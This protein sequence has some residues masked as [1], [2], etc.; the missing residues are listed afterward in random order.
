MT[1]CYP[2]PSG[3]SYSAE[4]CS[5]SRLLGFETVFLHSAHEKL[6]GYWDIVTDRL[7]KIRHC[8][9][10]PTLIAR[11]FAPCLKMIC[12][13]HPRLPRISRPLSHGTSNRS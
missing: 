13:A 9:N 5:A 6:L 12:S 10:V 2:K 1:T 7:D 3:L 8:Q 11:W 4:T